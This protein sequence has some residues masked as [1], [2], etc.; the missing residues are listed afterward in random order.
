[1]LYGLAYAAACALLGVLARWGRLSP[2]DVELLA[3][4]HEARARRRA[5]GRGA[6][7]PVDR[8]VL[9]ALSRRLP[10]RDWRVFPVHPATL[11][12][13]HRELLRPSGAP[14]AGDVG[15]DLPEGAENSVARSSRPVVRVVQPTEHGAGPD[16]AGRRAGDRRRRLELQGA[17]WSL[18]VVEPSGPGQ[19]RA[20]VGFV[21][22]EEVIQAFAAQGADEPFG[23]RVGPRRP[24]RGEQRLDAEPRARGTKSRP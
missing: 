3:L 4:R 18:P 2:D 9:A 7:R 24:D 23:D 11:R 21:D 5:G 8:L 14:T 19:N 16:R 17:V 10:G 6:W 13:W 1:M 20:Q 22:N 15:R 12:R